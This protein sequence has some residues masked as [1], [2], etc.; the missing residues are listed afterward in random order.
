[1]AAMKNFLTSLSPQFLA[2]ESGNSLG[3]CWAIKFCLVAWGLAYH[4]GLNQ[5]Q[6]MFIVEFQ[7]ACLS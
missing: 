2:T 5:Y 1:M 3:C 4:P 6:F 7:V